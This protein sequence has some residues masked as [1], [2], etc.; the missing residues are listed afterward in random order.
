M[1]RES[2]NRQ[3]V[4]EAT[5]IRGART[6]ATFPVVFDAIQ[7]PCGD[8]WKLNHPFRYA[9]VIAED[10]VS[11]PQQLLEIDREAIPR[12]SRDAKFLG[13]LE[14]HRAGDECRVRKSRLV[15]RATHESLGN[16]VAECGHPD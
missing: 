2:P 16:A 11:L 5:D 15:D 1:C 12:E 10:G 3:I 9:D 13:H 14:T 6:G 7:I 4:K 8:Q